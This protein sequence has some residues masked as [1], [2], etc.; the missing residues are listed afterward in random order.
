VRTSHI[1]ATRSVSRPAA[2]RRWIRPDRELPDCR[3]CEG[4]ALQILRNY[5]QRSAKNKQRLVLEMLYGIQAGKDVKLSGI[6]CSLNKPIPLI[7]TK[8]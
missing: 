8:E 5:F 4:T 1:K 6:T 3:G 7:K 2:N